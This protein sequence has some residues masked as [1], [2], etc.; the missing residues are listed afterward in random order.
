MQQIELFCSEHYF[1]TVLVCEET[2]AFTTRIAVPWAKNVHSWAIEEQHRGRAALGHAMAA[3][4]AARYD[5]EVNVCC[6]RRE[7]QQG[8]CRFAAD[9]GLLLEKQ[10]QF[11]RSYG[12]LIHRLGDSAQRIRDMKG[13]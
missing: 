9:V 3:L 11:E 4:D 8:V 6:G 7:L 2:Q 12:T 5:G 1:R 10:E 13:S